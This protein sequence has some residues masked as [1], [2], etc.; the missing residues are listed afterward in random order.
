[1]TQ[2]LLR[3][4]T[5]LVLAAGAC[6]FPALAEEAAPALPA[7]T[8]PAA[9]AGAACDGAAAELPWQD[10]NVLQVTG[11]SGCKAS[12]LCVH[13]GSV[14]CSSPNVGTCSA[15]GG[16]CGQVTCNGVTTRCPGY[17][18]GDQHCYNFCGGASSPNSYCDGGCC[19]CE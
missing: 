1:M 19:R 2:R 14:D 5:L 6:C 13:G 18:V 11:G 17:C 12:W 16:G 7:A 15:S 3:V 10:S 9:D 4:A 8:S